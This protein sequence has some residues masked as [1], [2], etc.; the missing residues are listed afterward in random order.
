M[1][2]NYSLLI[3]LTI[4]FL[5]KAFTEKVNAQ[6]NLTSQKKLKVGVYNNPPKIFTEDGEPQGI[7]IDVI[8]R[9][10]DKENFQADYV[11]GEWSKLREM[12]QKG[13]IDILPDV[14]YSVERDSLYALNSLA[15]IESW[16]EVFAGERQGVKSVADLEGK[17]I[18]VLSG[19]VQEQ[20]LAIQIP[21]DFDISFEL[22]EFDSPELVVSALKKKEIDFLVGD[23]F[24]KFSEKFTNDLF[25]TGIIMRPTELHFAFAKDTPQEL[26]ALF[27]KNLSVLKND[28]DSVYYSSLNNLLKRYEPG[29]PPFLKWVIIGILCLLVLVSGIAILFQY[30]VRKKTKELR[31]RN[32]ELDKARIKAE[33]N[34]RLKTAFLQNMSHEIRTPMNGIIGFMGL[35]KSPDLDSAGRKN[36]IEIVIESGKRLLSTI[37]NIIEISK[38]TSNEV[39]VKHDRVNVR[40][41]MKFHLEFFKISAD[42]KNII[43]EISRQIKVDDAFIETDQY[44]LDGVLTNLLNNAIKFTDNGK[45]TFGNYFL[46]KELVFYVEDSGAGMPKNRLD[47]IFEPFV[48]ADS[49]ISRPYEGSGLGLSIVK[50]YLDLL[51][52]KIWVESDKGKGSTFYFSIPYKKLECEKPVEQ[53]LD[54]KTWASDLEGNLKVLVAEDD[55]ISFLLIKQLLS[56]FQMKVLRAKNGKEA[57]EQFRENTDFALILM[58][59]KMPVMNGIDATRAIRK[60]NK[61][62][63]IIAQTAFTL[64]G[65]REIVMDAG[66]TA[67]ISKPIN[68]ENLL[69]LVE[70]HCGALNF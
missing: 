46:E 29:I 19:S 65:D 1:I 3:F 55:N 70:K 14:A 26:I 52:G 16:L 49:N 10:S 40:E 47:A 21:Q 36:Y 51:G 23:R 57:V 44:M 5:L 41:V 35:L 15:V 60:I 31:V 45:V 32:D 66:C 63:P 13:E 42:E 24:L 34:E 27:D 18:G 12:L 67:F 43:L 56:S 6:N 48:Q 11:I 68:K 7:F 53:T 54:D 38:I 30:S 33:E 2:K 28:L 59:I 62:I 37:N 4:A 17:R 50:R 8:S 20:Y 22:V 64:S 61:D 39:T 69:H 9:I 58:D 25:P